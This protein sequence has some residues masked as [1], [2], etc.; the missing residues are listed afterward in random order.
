MPA[1]ECIMAN[2]GRHP[3]G[4][5]RE[6]DD[7]P[8]GMPKPGIAAMIATTRRSLETV[9]SAAE[10]IQ[11]LDAKGRAAVESTPADEDETPLTPVP[12]L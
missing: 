7:G 9:S 12:V 1:A 4:D 8:A 5:E 10:L 6:D 3:M 2:P 11:R